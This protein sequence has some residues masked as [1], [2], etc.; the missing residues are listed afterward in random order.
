MFIRS[1]S[2]T[3]ANPN[4][5]QPRPAD[6]L[7]QLFPVSHQGLLESLARGA[8]VTGGYCSCTPVLQ[9]VHASSRRRNEAVALP[10]VQSNRSKSSACPQNVLRQRAR[11][12]LQ[13]VA[14]AAICF[15]RSTSPRVTG[16]GDR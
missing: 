2:S 4:D 5:Q 7:C 3:S 11:I 9:R 8:V 13:D 6:L 15:E 12:R 14:P 1:I 10:I 16:L